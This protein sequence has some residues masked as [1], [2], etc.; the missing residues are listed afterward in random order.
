M[1]RRTWLESTEYGLVLVSLVGT[2]IA[3]V[4]QQVVVALLPV[5]LALLVNLIHRSQLEA[6]QQQLLLTALESLNQRYGTD[7]KF[8]RRRLQDVLLLP[9]P[10]NLTPLEQSLQELHNALGNLHREMNQRLAS[11][12]GMNL[13]P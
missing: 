13:E 9:E 5:S 6:S 10:V 12:E 7:I 8:L 4:S 2:V 11:V 3:A 1:T